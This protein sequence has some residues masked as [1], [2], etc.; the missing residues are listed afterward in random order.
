VNACTFLSFRTDDT[1]SVWHQ[2]GYKTAFNIERS[3]FYQEAEHENTQK[4]HAWKLGAEVSHAKIVSS[5]NCA[6]EVCVNQ[7]CSTSV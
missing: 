5:L 2:L 1:L 3:T 4:M 6:M 7:I